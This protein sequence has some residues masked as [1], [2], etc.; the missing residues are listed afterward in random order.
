MKSKF[1]AKPKFDRI[2]ITGTTS[3]LG[4]AFLDYYYKLG[5]KVIVVNRREVPHLW[6]QYP[7]IEL[8]TLNITSKNEVHR[9]LGELRNKGT[10]PDLFVLNAGINRL[11][12]GCG[13]DFDTFKSVIDTNLYG[14]MSFV[15]AIH[16]LGISGKTIASLSSTSNIVPNPAHVAYYVSKRALYDAFKMLQKKDALNHYKTV[17]LGPV[18]TQIMAGYPEPQGLQKKIFDRLVVP[19][20]A[21]AV[22]CARFFE[23]GRFSFWY[24][25]LSIAFY[26]LVKLVL[27]FLPGLY[28]G[29][30]T[31]RQ[32]TQN[33]H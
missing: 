15:G 22:Q 23:S 8:H 11:D 2:L 5:C 12:N 6:R 9:F 16:D 20:D 21:T 33:Q 13:L 14:V 31:P 25:K 10:L 19:A 4:H 24:P 32:L 17:V 7:G 1:A 18:S 28:G 27:L 29:T 30:S 3:G 26:Q